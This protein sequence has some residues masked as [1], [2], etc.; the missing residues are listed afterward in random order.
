MRLLGHGIALGIG[1]HELVFLR[2][3]ELRCGSLAFQ[4]RIGGG[5]CIQLHGADRIVVAGNGVIDQAWIVVG[6]DHGDHRNAELLGF[7][8]GDV[9]MTDVDHEQRVRQAIHVLDAAEGLVE[10]FLLADQAQHL[11]LD[12]FLE[13]AVGGHGFDFLQARDRGLDRAEIGE[14]AAEPA[15]SDI[16]HAATDRFFLH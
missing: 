10:F 6:I 13:A 16:G 7:L 8:D 2:R 14:H 15:C 3:G 9:F 1:F 5:V 4:D 12:Q 11:V